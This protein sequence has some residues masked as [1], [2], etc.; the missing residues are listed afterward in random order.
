M[1]SKSSRIAGATGQCLLVS[2]QK[3]LSLLFAYM[4]SS[5]IYYVSVYNAVIIQSSKILYSLVKQKS[6]MIF[7]SFDIRQKSNG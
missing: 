2:K 6:W 3:A 1:S 4:L 5:N 7:L